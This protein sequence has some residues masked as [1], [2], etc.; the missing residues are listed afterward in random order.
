MPGA[1]LKKQNKPKKYCKS[2][3]LD[4]AI[5]VTLQNTPALNTFL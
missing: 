5:I 3:L 4:I 1:K 2:A